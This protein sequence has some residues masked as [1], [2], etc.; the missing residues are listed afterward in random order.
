M[1]KSGKGPSMLSITLILYVTAA[2]LWAQQGGWPRTTAQSEDGQGAP[3]GSL[4][5]ALRTVHQDAGEEDAWVGPGTVSEP[6]KRQDEP[7]PEYL[8][9]P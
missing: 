3:L 6:R 8:E 1:K 4:A 2:R 9:G 7:S 5:G